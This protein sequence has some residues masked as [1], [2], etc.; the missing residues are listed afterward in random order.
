MKFLRSLFLT[1]F[2]AGLAS[3]KTL[4]A[5]ANI[6]TVP[7]GDRYTLTRGIVLGPY[8]QCEI[9]QETMRLNL[10]IVI[11]STKGAKVHQERI[12]SI[13]P[14]C[15]DP[16]PNAHAA[17]KYMITVPT[18]PTGLLKCATILGSPGDGAKVG[19]K[20][21]DKKHGYPNQ[22][23]TFD[24]YA[25]KQGNLCLDVTDGHDNNGVKLQVWTCFSGNTNQRF[26]HDGGN[27]V[28]FPDDRFTWHGKNKCVDLTDGSVADSNPLQ[29]WDCDPANTNQKW[30]LQVHHP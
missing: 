18:T 17:G 12:A 9:A 11:Y 7:N 1:A 8:L 23:W 13:N 27:L 24:G 25:F 29:I 20:T 4:K 28:F 5:C 15:V 30:T 14:G 26:D 3:G 6:L 22:V 16:L 10:S 21:C 2:C 19:I